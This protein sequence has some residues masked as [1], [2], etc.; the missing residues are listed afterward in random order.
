[1]QL[2]EF[3]LELM[4]QDRVILI[5]GNHE[6]Q[7]FDHYPN[8]APYYGKGIIALD[9]CTAFSGKINGIVIEDGSI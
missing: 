6:D 3:F 2:Q 5:R 1:M 7:E 8:F 9:V 4:E